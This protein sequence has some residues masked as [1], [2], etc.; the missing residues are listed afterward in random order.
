MKSKTLL[1]IVSLAALSLSACA[2]A[3]R[4]G[5]MRARSQWRSAAPETRQSVR[6]NRAVFNLVG[7]QANVDVICRGAGAASVRTKSNGWDVLFFVVTGGL[8]TPQH[9]YIVCNGPASG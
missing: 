1:G 9:S 2:G 5:E 7:Q 6:L 4:T 8:Y 3:Q